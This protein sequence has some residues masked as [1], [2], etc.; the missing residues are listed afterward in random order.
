[1]QNEKC[2]IGAYSLLF[3]AIIF[4]SATLWAQT[5][6]RPVPPPIG[7]DFIGTMH[8]LSSD[9]MEGREAGASGGFMA[10]DY[11][12]SMMQQYGLAPL[13][14]FDQSVAETSKGKSGKPP[15]QPTYF[16]NFEVV[17]YKVEKATL[18]F[19]RHT[20]TSKTELQLSPGID[21]EL[22]SGPNGMEAEG[23]LVFAGYGI[24]VPGIGYDDY[25]GLDVNGRVAVVLTGFPGHADTTSMAW[26]N[27]GK[28]H[29]EEL[30][31][32]E[33]KLRVAEKHGAVALIIVTPDGSFKPYS[34]SQSNL[35]IVQAA[36]NSPKITDRRYDDPDYALPGDTS[37]SN[38]PCFSL[39]PRVTN[40][41]FDGTGII[42]KDFET[43]IARDLSP[44]SL[45]LKDKMIGFSVLVKSESLVVRNVLGI[46][47]GKDSTKSIV[48]GAHYD[49]LGIRNGQIYHGADD[50]ASGSSGMLALAKVWMEHG[51][52]PA[53][54]I[55][56]AAWTAEEKGLLG[57]SYFVKATKANPEKTLIYINMDMISRNA[58]EDTA[59]SILSIGTRPGDENLRKIANE[60]NLRLSHPFKLD[61]WDVTGHT[62]SDYASFTAVKV[63]VMTFF[64]GFHE[65]YHTPRDVAAKADTAK[66]AE[67]LKIANDGIRA[68]AQSPFPK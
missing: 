4:W 12:S 58:P 55:I 16:Q 37:V 29:G 53:C 44:A 3:P 27:F 18:A 63:P 36:M 21:F 9:W 10:A 5:G 46:I 30:S 42:L 8:F 64:S 7:K 60:S 34:Q 35:D 39:G 40:L 20:A 6:L 49:H 57:S 38:A 65:D 59:H 31:S 2:K 26:K 32:L 50:N 33:E 28:N 23:Q 56:F 11:I 1:M 19:N 54:N 22:R 52:P 66:M 15:L 67:I 24:S 48:V 68:F 17:R 47:R 62:G 41:L 51:E 14:D 45:P 25:K 13:G 61:L 43:K